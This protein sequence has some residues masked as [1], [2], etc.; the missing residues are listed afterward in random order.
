[1]ARETINQFELLATFTGL[2]AALNFYD[3]KM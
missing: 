3:Y 1:M 2:L